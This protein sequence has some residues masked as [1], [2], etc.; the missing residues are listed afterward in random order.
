[1]GSWLPLL[2]IIATGKWPMLALRLAST[3][4]AQMKASRFFYGSGLRKEKSSISGLDFDRYPNHL[5]V[6]WAEGIFQEAK[7]PFAHITRHALSYCIITSK[8]K[9]L[10]LNASKIIPIQGR[11]RQPLYG[12]SVFEIEDHDP[13]LTCET[14]WLV[15][16][17]AYDGAKENLGSQTLRCCTRSRALLRWYSRMH[18]FLRCWSSTLFQRTFHVKTVAKRT[19]W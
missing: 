5:T 19:L 8:R 16:T 10:T 17:P 14:C 4:F 3:V 11:S 6:N 12:S 15:S 2:A 13:S 1:M 9:L 18:S 7:N